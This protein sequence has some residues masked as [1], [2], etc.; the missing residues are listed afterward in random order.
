VCQLDPSSL[1]TFAVADMLAILVVFL[2]LN[3]WHTSLEAHQVIGLGLALL[4]SGSGPAGAEAT[5]MVSE[6]MSAALEVQHAVAVAAITGKA[7][8]IPARTLAIYR[9]T[10]R[11]NRHRLGAAKPPATRLARQDVKECRCDCDRLV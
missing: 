3:I 6:K 9:R 2:S 1:W 10:I 11:G 7:E 4:A 5:R 8:L